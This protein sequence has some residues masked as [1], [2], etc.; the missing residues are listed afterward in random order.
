LSFCSNFFFISYY[1]SNIHP[2]DV[3]VA[4]T[5]V[6]KH[7]TGLKAKSAVAIVLSFVLQHPAAEA[8]ISPV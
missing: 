3:L 5:A 4:F 6:F 1:Y 7:T 8:P 2:L